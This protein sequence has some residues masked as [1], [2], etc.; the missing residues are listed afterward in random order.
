MSRSLRPFKIVAFI[1]VLLAAPLLGQSGVLQS[2]RLVVE[3]IAAESVAA[4]AGLRVEDRVISYDGQPLYSPA[5]LQAAEKNTFGKKEVVLEV[6]RGEETLRFT[7]PL[8]ALGIQARPELPPSIAQ[9]YREGRKAMAASQSEQALASW[10]DAAQQAQLEGELQAAAWLYGLVGEEREHE[11]NWAQ[12][13][14]AHLSKWEIIKESS[15][16]AAHSR[17]LS[18]LGRCRQN[19]NDFPAAAK[20]FEQARQADEAGGYELWIS[21]DLS[22]LGKLAWTRGDLAAAQNYFTDSMAIR[23]SL[24][25]GS[26]LVADNLSNLGG[27]FYLRGDL[28]AAEDVSLR[29]FAIRQRLSPN[30]LD[31]AGSLNNL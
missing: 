23:E 30:S 3:E 29:S 22:N 11:S 5:A 16:W 20:L 25:P 27:V 26:L 1:T 13:C 7:I 8:G 6:Q 17:T 31:A 28:A 14:K 9:Q 10:E 15:D 24:V 18:A 4:K 2:S 21:D 19:Q 12:A